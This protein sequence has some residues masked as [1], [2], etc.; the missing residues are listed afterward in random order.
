MDVVE[1]YIVKVLNS[2]KFFNTLLITLILYK[3]YTYFQAGFNK[4]F[5]TSSRNHTNNEDKE[6][7]DN[8]NLQCYN[9]YNFTT[10]SNCNEHENLS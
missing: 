4:I 7:G 6:L 5:F 8:S 2:I 1:P 10:N 9:I 3:K